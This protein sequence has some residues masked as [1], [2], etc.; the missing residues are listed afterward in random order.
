L[1]DTATHR[2]NIIANM[3][4][5]W[6]TTHVVSQELGHSLRA[7]SSMRGIFTA[8]VVMLMVFLGSGSHY[9]WI[10]LG[11]IMLTVSVD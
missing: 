4:G 5:S 11:H 6:G 2:V 7:V 1:V 9:G 10:L 3:S 8:L